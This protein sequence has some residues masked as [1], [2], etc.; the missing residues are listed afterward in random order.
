MYKNIV[1][2]PG[3]SRAAAGASVAAEL[4]QQAE[5]GGKK[6]DDPL[7]GALPPAVDNEQESHHGVVCTDRN[8]PRSQAVWPRTAAER[9]KIT[10]GFGSYWT[11]DSAE[12]ATWPSKDRDRYTGDF[13]A[14]TS[15]P[16]LIVNAK[17]DP[18]TH[19][20]SAVSLARTMPGAQ[21]LTL[22]G[23]GHSNIA[24]SSCLTSATGKY[25]VSGKLSGLPR[26][27]EQDV[28]PFPAGGQQAQQR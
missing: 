9:D 4:E 13:E 8:S 15:N 6:K 17:F 16:T 3:K 22:N 23:Y 26:T 25:L 18:S 19:Y 28:K 1:T 14:R 11:F 12:C 10:P 21:L 27:C 20:R 2:G 24:T 5:L 7:R